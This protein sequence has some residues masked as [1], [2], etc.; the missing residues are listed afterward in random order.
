MRGRGAKEEE[1]A[2]FSTESNWRIRMLR[3]VI[4]FC[5]WVRLSFAANYVTSHWKL[6]DCVSEC[7]NSRCPSGHRIYSGV[8]SYL[9]AILT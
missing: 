2:S 5:L 6:T 1:F 3:A 8:S 9:S 7:S 4:C